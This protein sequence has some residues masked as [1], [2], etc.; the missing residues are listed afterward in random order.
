MPHTR[1]VPARAEYV[2]TEKGHHDLRVADLCQCNPRLAGLLI[3]C[4]DCGTVYGSLRDSAPWA[5]GSREK[6]DR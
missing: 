2:V 3:E 1:S 4:P 6:F 5:S